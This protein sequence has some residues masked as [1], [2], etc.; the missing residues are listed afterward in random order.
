MDAGGLQ[1]PRQAPVLNCVGD[2]VT[3]L[4]LKTSGRI[5]EPYVGSYEFEIGNA[6]FR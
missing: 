2:E 5:F 4:N 1:S 3:R 6:I